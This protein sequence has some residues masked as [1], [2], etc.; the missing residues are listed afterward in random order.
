MAEGMLY[1]RIGLPPRIVSGD[2]LV[3]SHCGLTACYL[4]CH[5]TYPMSR[6]WGCISTSYQSPYVLPFVYADLGAILLPTIRSTDMVLRI[7]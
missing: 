2:R 6:D 5:R 3:L 4:R 1:I 7:S